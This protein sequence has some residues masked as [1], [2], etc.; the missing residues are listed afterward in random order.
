MSVPNKQG[1]KIKSQEELSEFVN[2][3][4]SEV[5]AYTQR[6]Y[7]ATETEVSFMFVLDVWL[8]SLQNALKK[9]RKCECHSNAINID[10]SQGVIQGP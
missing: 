1:I 2:E 8:K 3:V 9:K 5:Q 7:Q 4:S 10:L 6:K